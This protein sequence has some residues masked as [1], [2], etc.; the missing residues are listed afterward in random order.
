MG[1]RGKGMLMTFTEVPPEHEEDFNEWY[2]REHLDERVGMPGFRRARRYV[3]LRADPKYFATYET[4]TVADLAAPDYLKLLADQSPWSK[5]VM[6]RFSKF[7][8]LTL[9][10]TVDLAHGVGGGVAVCRFFPRPEAMRP[11]RAWLKEAALPEAI[12]RPGMLGAFVGENDL[13]VANAPARAQGVDFPQASEQ[14][15]AVLFEA[16]DAR[17]ALAAAR[18]ALAELKARGVPRPAAFGAYSL[19]FGNER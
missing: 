1:L 10:I 18:E 8:R 3:A 11:L 6:K 13:D 14:E 2:N 17:T 9:K 4:K 12:R 19:Q 15:W 7:H 16:A 5:R